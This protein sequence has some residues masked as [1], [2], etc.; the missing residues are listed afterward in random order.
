MTHWVDAGIVH[1][2]IAELHAGSFLVSGSSSIPIPYDGIAGPECRHFSPTMSPPRR[3]LIHEI[4]R[5]LSRSPMIHILA[6]DL[7]RILEP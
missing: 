4:N 1:P 5:H 6:P 3:L 7:K 2:Y